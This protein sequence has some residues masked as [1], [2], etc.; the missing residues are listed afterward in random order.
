V[1]DAALV[2]VSQLGPLVDAVHEHQLPAVIATAAVPPPA[3][4]DWLVGEIA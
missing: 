3:A 2:I 4:S 1:P